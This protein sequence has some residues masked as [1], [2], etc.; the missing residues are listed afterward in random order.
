MRNALE[1]E[2][3]SL[4]FHGIRQRNTPWMDGAG[5]VSHCSIN[6]GETFQYRCRRCDGETRGVQPFQG[7]SEMIRHP[8][9]PGFMFDHNWS[10]TARKCHSEPGWVFGHRHP[11]LPIWGVWPFCYTGRHHVC[12]SAF[13]S[14]GEEGVDYGVP[15]SGDPELASSA[16][17]VSAAK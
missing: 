6:P 3:T 8:V 9:A 15:S 11:W 13:V 16:A 12:R 4:H 10:D 7:V 14:D 17:F 1:N 5:G 2:A